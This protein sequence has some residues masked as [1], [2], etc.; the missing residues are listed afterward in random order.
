MGV[1]KPEYEAVEEYAVLAQKLVDKYPQVFPGLDPSQIRCY[2]IINKE[3]PSS[4][5]IWEIHAVKQPI[6]LDCPYNWYVVVYQE[7]WEEMDE[8]LQAKLVAATLLS[9]GEEGKVNSFDLKD[10][11]VMVKTFGVD[12]LDNAEGPD[13]LNEDV[14]WEV[15]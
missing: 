14:N 12:Y 10:H 9:V 15:R 6:N 8:K 7:D 2:S 5:S 4:K 13:L 3:R 11:K 1:Q